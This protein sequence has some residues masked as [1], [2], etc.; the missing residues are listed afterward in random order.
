MK[1][2]K[3]I[4]FVLT[5]DDLFDDEESPPG[6]APLV[7][8]AEA[9]LMF[10]GANSG[11]NNNKCRDRTRNNRNGSNATQKRTMNDGGE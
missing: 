4:L 1:K 2:Y 7:C 10:D 3:K 8:P 9:G 5:F 11:R 6:K